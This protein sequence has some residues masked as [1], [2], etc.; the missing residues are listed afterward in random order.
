MNWQPIDTAPK[1]G[2]EILGV[3]VPSGPYE[4]DFS[5]LRWD[6]KD[7]VGLCD[8]EMSIRA[9]GDFGTDYHEP[10]CTHWMPLPETAHL[11]DITT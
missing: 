5:I 10:F 2:T 7:W 1:D 6:G 9:Q 11:K 3:F 8:G 4:P